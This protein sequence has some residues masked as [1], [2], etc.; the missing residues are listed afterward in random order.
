M[1]SMKK[2]LKRFSFLGF[3]VSD[4]RQQ[5]GPS[6]VSHSQPKTIFWRTNSDVFFQGTEQPYS[7]LPWQSSVEVGDVTAYLLINNSWSAREGE[8]L[9]LINKLACSP[10]LFVT[11]G[12]F[13]KHSQIVWGGLVQREGHH[14]QER[15]CWSLVIQALT[16]NEGA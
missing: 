1:Q 12:F 3:I 2:N 11:H 14:V 7:F 6:V 15:V 8:D 10:P 9:G 13:M 4:Y 16:W 5:K